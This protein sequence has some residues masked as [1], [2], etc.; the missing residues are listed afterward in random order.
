MNPTRDLARLERAVEA[1]ERSAARAA[2]KRGDMP[3]QDA[4]TRPAPEIIAPGPRTE[5][6]K[7]VTRLNATRHGM[8]AE[9]IPPAE[10]EDYAAHVAQL[11]EHYAPV[12]Y[13]EAHL[14][15]RIASALWRLRRV[16]RYE[17]AVAARDTASALERARERRSTHGIDPHGIVSERVE[18]LERA[19]ELHDLGPERL[20]L[21]PAPA[22][23]DWVWGWWHL[24]DTAGHA[25]ERLEWRI[26]KALG[27][28]RD[29]E[30]TE[31]E[32]RWTFA[33][34]CLAVE[35]FA[36]LERGRVVKPPAVLA[37]WLEYRDRLRW[38]LERA[39]EEAAAHARAETHAAALAALPHPGTLEKIAKY[40]AHLERV[41]YKALH[42]LEALQDKRRGDA[43]P[44]ARMEV[45]G[46]EG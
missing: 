8:L 30:W 10:A 29:E 12:G 3:N 11:L 24:A 41:A 7:A 35:G 31:A 39:G 33:A 42:E 5:A 4:L 13:L 36:A 27:L 26:A 16:E 46:R 32:T 37:G 45:H 6:G 40:E 9:L 14:V 2:E 28:K 43:A 21:E 15:D 18:A 38:A 25:G 22:L 19:L 1:L 17:A 20:A 44:L 23:F 34:A